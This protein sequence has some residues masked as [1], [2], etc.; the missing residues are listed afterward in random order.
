MRVT[1]LESSPVWRISQAHWISTAASVGVPTGDRLTRI[2]YLRTSR[3]VGSSP[4]VVNSS[5]LVHRRNANGTSYLPIGHVRWTTNPFT[6]SLS[7][8]PPTTAMPVAILHSEVVYTFTY[9]DSGLTCRLLSP[10]RNQH[11]HT[12]PCCWNSSWP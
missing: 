11:I 9:P 8:I 12:R 6:I 4:S 3:T 5:R 2:Q 7:D 1:S 10:C